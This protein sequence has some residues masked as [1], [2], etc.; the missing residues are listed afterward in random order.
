MGDTQFHVSIKLWLVAWSS[1][2]VWRE[3]VPSLPILL[4]PPHQEVVSHAQQLFWLTQHVM[5]KRKK[6]D[7]Y[8]IK[9]FAAAF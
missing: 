7:K 2:D 9:V 1:V 6:V 8:E 5:R 4:L 3:L